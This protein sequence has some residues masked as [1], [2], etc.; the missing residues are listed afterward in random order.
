M[1]SVQ[2]MRCLVHVVVA[3]QVVVPPTVE[4][5]LSLPPE[6]RR[7]KGTEGLWYTAHEKEKTNKGTPQDGQAATDRYGA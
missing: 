1:D 3:A 7:K 4:S 5:A 6:K 2:E